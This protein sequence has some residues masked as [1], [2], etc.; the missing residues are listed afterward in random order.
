MTRI[1]PALAGAVALTLSTLT[2]QAQSA[3]DFYKGKTISLVISSSAGGG[4]D[5]L[6]RTIARHLPKHIPGAPVVAVRNMPGAGGIVAT[7]FLYNIASKDGLTIG[8]VQNNTPFEPLLGTKEAD[9]DPKKFNWLGSPSYE[10]GLLIVWH[11]VAAATVDE[12]R[13]TEI[14]VSSSGAN[15]TPSF[16]ARL[17]TELLGLKLKIVVGYP[18]QNESFIAMER[19]EVDGYPSI[20]WSSLAATRPDWIKNKR[21]KYVVQYGPEK[22]KDAGDTP[23]VID[24][25]T[26]E[27]DK[28]LLNA[29]IAPLALG[30]PYLMPPGVPAD[31]VALMQKAMMATFADP[32]FLAEAD[33]LNLGVNV[34]RSPEQMAKLVEEAY[35]TPPAIVERLRR[36]ANPAGK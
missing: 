5:T 26:K 8:G 30:R 21:V 29:A 27:D 33:K 19:G 4:Y 32:D 11:T 6:A 12:V 15:S 31:R 9:Y 35:A 24:Y 28:L 14:T 18:G 16:F 1:L 23:S 13:K 36:I 7:N 3:A 34:P 22:E 2:A 20:F 17:L 10:T 25:L